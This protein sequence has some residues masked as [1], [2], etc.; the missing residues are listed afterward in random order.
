MPICTK[1]NIAFIGREGS[2]KSTQAHELAKYLDKP[3][4]STGEILRELAKNDQGLWGK[5]CR[6]M[7]EK[8]VYLDGQMLIDILVDRLSQKDC[9]D[10]FIL[11]GGLRTLKETIIFK[12]MLVSAGRD[13]PLMVIHL[14]L[15]GWKSIDR[16]V[17]G[18]SA[19][20]RSD[21]TIE[22]VLARLTKYQ[23]QLVERIKVIKSTNGWQIL[24]IDA[25]P[26]QQ[27]VFNEIIEKLK[28]ND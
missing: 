2:G 13:Y 12:D 18:E 16:L 1:E 21:D 6:D 15:P 4:I 23:Y 14:R 27:S 22:A 28:L 24:N 25:Q 10:G 17:T 11:D 7:F 8:S 26:G 19:R 3:C 5:A 20:G 9:Q